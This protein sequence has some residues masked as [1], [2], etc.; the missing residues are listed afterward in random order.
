MMRTSA[1]TLLRSIADDHDLMCSQSVS[2]TRET[3][4]D[5]IC[6]CD[7]PSTCRPEQQRICGEEQNRRC[8]PA[9][10]RIYRLDLPGRRPSGTRSAGSISMPLSDSACITMWRTVERSWAAFRFKASLT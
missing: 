6:A 10:L 8:A 7:Q 1:H 2:R 4:H 3:P 5:Q 9:Q